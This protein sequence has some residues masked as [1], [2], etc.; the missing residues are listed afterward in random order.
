MQILDALHAG[1]A[2]AAVPTGLIVA[3]ETERSRL[4]TMCQ[5][6]RRLPRA[7]F[8][9]LCTDA[10]YFPGMRRRV[11]QDTAA[12]GWKQKYDRV[13]ADVPCSGDGTLRKN[14][15]QWRKWSVKDGL[16]LHYLQLRILKR[17]I[18]LLGNGSTLVYSTCTLNPIE[19]EAVVAAALEHF[20]TD[21]VEL[22]P[23]PSWMMDQVK[24]C[25]GLSE[26]LVPVP[27]FEKATGASAVDGSTTPMT[28]DN[29]ERVMY[30]AFSDVPQK[31]QKTAGKGGG[32]LGRT[33]FPPPDVA[34]T[35]QLH[36]CGRVLPTC[37]DSGGFFV[38]I[39]KRVRGG[40]PNIF[41]PPE[42][43]EPEPEQPEPEPVSKPEAASEQE[44][45]QEQ[46]P[47]PAV[48]AES[49]GTDEY[50]EGDWV[51][52]K[53]GCGTNNF[54]H[55]EV[56]FKCKSKKPKDDDSAKRNC[57]EE[58]KAV[59]ERGTS[60]LDPL[61]VRFAEGV[62]K[63]GMTADIDLLNGFA[64][65]YGLI[66]D[67][68]AAAAAGVARFP[69]ESVRLLRR[70]NQRVLVLSSEALDRLAISDKWAPATEVGLFL[71]ALPTV[72]D[73]AEAVR[74]QEAGGMPSAEQLPQPH[75]W[76]VYD[77]AA[78][79]LAQCAT[80]RVLRLPP[81][82]YL[83]V[84]EAA[85]LEPPESTSEMERTRITH[86]LNRP[87]IAPETPWWQDND[88]TDLLA[89][90]AAPGCVIVGC[91][92]ELDGERGHFSV[93]ARLEVEGGRKVAVE[94]SA[95]LTVAQVILLDALLALQAESLAASE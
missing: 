2:P 5:R 27:N 7:P 48:E 93:S 53:K 17:G 85:V 30:A 81:P 55:R 62:S 64:E 59:S 95:R 73:Q 40:S 47:E 31:E 43:P 87:V 12:Q 79:V 23:L 21:F 39:I 56:C 44:Q 16:S 51:C 63:Y 20:G 76:Q 86:T 58:Y 3:N 22:Q 49:R 13:L 41:V 33:M 1:L 19:D 84:L 9:A 36:R 82:L 37:I 65:A 71:A 18:E 83:R 61:L 35:S 72:K 29:S 26:W 75:Q 6:A 69:L 34:I 54:A 11:A 89:E 91:E 94:T 10:R 8:L 15:T 38:A 25:S 42:Q 32:M 78:T 77:E 66:S 90:M 74:V 70:P 52:Q 67:A 4:L 80:K 46:E 45:E 68:E 92:V 88:V 28:G 57:E 60:G 50:R 14:R 24:P